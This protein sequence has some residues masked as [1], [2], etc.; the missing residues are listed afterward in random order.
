MEVGGEGGHG[1]GSETRLH[2]RIT[3][4]TLKRPSAQTAL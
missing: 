3:W 2:I 4:R 1:H